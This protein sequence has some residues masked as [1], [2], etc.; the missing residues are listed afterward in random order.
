MNWITPTKR[1]WNGHNSSGY[2]SDIIAVNGF[3][4]DMQYGGLSTEV[5]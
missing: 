1:S 5:I 2:K 4:H 3:N